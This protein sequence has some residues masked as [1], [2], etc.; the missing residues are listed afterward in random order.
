MNKGETTRQIWRGIMNAREADIIIHN[1]I[2]FG[3]P[4]DTKETIEKTFRFA[5]KLNAEFTQFSITTPLPGT[6]YYE[7]M[8]KER[9]IILALGE[10]SLWLKPPKEAPSFRMAIIALE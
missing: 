3:F 4:W 9:R 6:P 8:M 1:C 7:M 10:I 5:C 2:M